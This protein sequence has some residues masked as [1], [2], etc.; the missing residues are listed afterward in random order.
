M[1]AALNGR[2]R[3][4]ERIKQ[5]SMMS[6]QE[7]IALAIAI[8][9]HNANRAYC[10][11]IGDDSQPVWDQAPDWQKESA[12]AGV[13]G[14]L[15]GDITTP[16]QSHES[17]LAVKKADG[18]RY[19]KVKDASAKTHPCFMSYADLPAEQKKKDFIFSN[20]VASAKKVFG[21]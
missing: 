13:R 5:E 17:W 9:C 10:Q 7:T 8:A 6:E 2:A 19:G 3:L 14:H 21:L 12:L 20:T 11:S 16:E 4:L 1:N 15:S 18:W